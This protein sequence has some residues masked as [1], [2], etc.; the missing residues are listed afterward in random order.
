M[1]VVHYEDLRNNTAEE[2]V[3]M[4]EFLQ[5][6]YE[7][8]HVRQAIQADSGSFHRKHLSNFNPFTAKQ[9]KLISRILASAIQSAQRNKYP[10]TARLQQYLNTH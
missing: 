4:L 2:V 6:P 9:H 1:L 7:V 8:D 3:R 10:G 5:V